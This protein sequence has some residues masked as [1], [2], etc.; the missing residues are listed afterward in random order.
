MKEKI[1]TI[2]KG[3][4]LL[5]KGPALVNVHSGE[6]HC[7]MKKIDKLVVRK[8]KVLPIETD[9]A[10]AHIRILLYEDSEYEIHEGLM[11]TLIWMDEIVK[12]LDRLKTEIRSA[13][14]IG[15]IDAGKSTL[16]VLL[17]NLAVLKKL[18]VGIIDGDVGQADLTP[19][20]F[21]GAKILEEQIYDLRD[22]K[23]DFALPI[24][25]IDVALASELIIE[26]IK[27]MKE[28]LKECDLIIVN[29][30]GYLEGG[31]ISYKQKLINEIKP[32]VTFLIGEGCEG[33]FKGISKE[34]IKLRMPTGISKSKFTRAIRREMQYNRFLG[35]E[36]KYNLS[37]K[38]V[39]IGFFGKTFEGFEKEG[40]TIIKNSFEGWRLKII[41]FEENFLAIN[42]QMKSIDI[43]TSTMKDMVVGLEDEG[44]I[45]GYG[46]I[47]YIFQDKIKI[48]TNVKSYLNKIWLTTVKLTE[49]GE[50]KIPLI[51]I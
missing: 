38:D 31:G 13:I 48:N 9:E 29:T 34:L 45:K 7:L 46:K 28:F 36:M 8:G 42:N 19:P 47:V 6:A 41:D 2:H 18:K 16:T 51:K 4:V 27:R 15:P 1:V 43:S 17:S 35:E 25:V 3:E 32:D 30:D 24:G 20:C 26:N 33:E 21:I 10:A 40:R 22:V 37:I 11:G 5:I 49:K 14:I 44:I 39:S 23:A 12:I 50:F